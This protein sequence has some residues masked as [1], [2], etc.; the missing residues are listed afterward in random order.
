[1]RLKE[2]TLLV[3]KR[4]RYVRTVN[5]VWQHWWNLWDLLRHVC[6]GS[7][8]LHSSSHT[9]T[10]DRRR[11][12]HF[13]SAKWSADAFTEEQIDPFSSVFPFENQILG[14]K[15]FP[16]TYYLLRAYSH[17]L[18]RQV[19]V[20]VNFSVNATL[21]TVYVCVLSLQSLQECLER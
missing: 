2:V 7:L 15:C 1:M 18:L 4:K 11:L 6:L 14:P 21:R 16:F 3:H 5:C 10:L 17:W 12:L 13:L 19:D 9:P 8:G 20:V